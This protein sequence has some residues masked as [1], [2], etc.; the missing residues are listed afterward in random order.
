MEFGGQSQEFDSPRTYFKGTLQELWLYDGGRVNHQLLVLQVQL[1]E[2]IEEFQVPC[3]NLV[4][5]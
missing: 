1:G 5:E 2:L 4:D 3:L